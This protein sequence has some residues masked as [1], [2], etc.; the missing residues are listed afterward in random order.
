MQHSNFIEHLVCEISSTLIEYKKLNKSNTK[1]QINQDRDQ[2]KRKLQKIKEIKSKR[3][4]TQFIV[5]R[6]YVYAHC[7]QATTA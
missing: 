1:M 6:Q 3:V 5:V 2:L 7:H 4:Q